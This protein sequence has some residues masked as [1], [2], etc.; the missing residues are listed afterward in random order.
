MY[1]WG[2][3]SN[4]EWDALPEMEKAEKIELLRELGMMQAVEAEM[5]KPRPGAIE[6]KT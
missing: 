6:G 5:F 3:K 2:I 1:R 4:A